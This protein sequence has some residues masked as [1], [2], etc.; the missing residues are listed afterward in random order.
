LRIAI[1]SYPKQPAKLAYLPAS[2][3]KKDLRKHLHVIL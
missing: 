1:R 3:Q 2:H